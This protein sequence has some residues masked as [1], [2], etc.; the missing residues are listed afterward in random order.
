[1]TTLVGFVPRKR[2]N[3]ELLLVVFA[4]VISIAAY[5]SVGLGADDKVPADIMTYGGD[6]V[7]L[8]LI[9]HVVVRLRAPYA[10]PVMLPLALLLNGLGLAMIYRIDLA[11][12]ADHGP[13]AETFAAQQLIWMTGGV[14]LFVA[15]LAR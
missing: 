13:H 4:L 12:L 2:R 8:G 6:V 1:M 3:I 14:G 9:S 5:A 10:D 11:N 15:I 7:A